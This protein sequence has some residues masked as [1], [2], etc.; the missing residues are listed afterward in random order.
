MNSFMLA[1]RELQQP[2]MLLQISTDGWVYVLMPVYVADQAGIQ[3]T[4]ARMLGCLNSMLML[5]LQTV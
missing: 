2:K 4:Q 1:K 5:T 3:L